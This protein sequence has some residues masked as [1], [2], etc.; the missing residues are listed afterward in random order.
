VDWLKTATR[1]ASITATDA[2]PTQTAME[3][4]GF[5][6]KHSAAQ[7]AGIDR[8]LSL[9]ARAAMDVPIGDETLVLADYGASQGRNSMAPDQ[10]AAHKGR[11]VDRYRAEPMCL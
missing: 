5:Y 9:L 6:N 3:G 11:G 2:V 10:R 4:A 7:A 1:E 8:I